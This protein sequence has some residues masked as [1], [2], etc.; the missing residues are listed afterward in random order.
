[1]ASTP[2]ASC[3]RYLAG[4]CCTLAHRNAY[5]GHNRGEKEAERD[6]GGAGVDVQPAP[7]AG[8]QESSR[9]DQPEQRTGG[10]RHGD[11]EPNGGVRVGH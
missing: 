6:E 7:R 3:N 10:E 11:G 8:V 4:G 2:Y 5:P 9:V 1:M